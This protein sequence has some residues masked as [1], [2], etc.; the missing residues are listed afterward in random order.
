MSG[1]I[2][3]SGA[4]PL[5]HED[6]HSLSPYYHTLSVDYDALMNEAMKPAL[7]GDLEKRSVKFAHPARK[8]L[9][10]EGGISCA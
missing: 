4:L 10:Q 8:L 5:G 1:T 2:S 9:S 7:K 3:W 6:A